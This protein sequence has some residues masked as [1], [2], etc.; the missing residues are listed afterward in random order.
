MISNGLDNLP[1]KATS[2]FDNLQ[3]VYVKYMLN[4]KEGHINLQ[5]KFYLIKDTPKVEYKL[6]R[7]IADKYLTRIHSLYVHLKASIQDKKK[8]SKTSSTTVPLLIFTKRIEHFTSKLSVT[9]DIIIVNE[10]IKIINKRI[11]ISELRHLD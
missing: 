5:Y 4:E 10:E 7:D 2:L 8:L 9:F 11:P 3:N 1:R 6:I